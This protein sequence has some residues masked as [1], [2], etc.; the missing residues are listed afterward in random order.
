MRTGIH[1]PAKPGAPMAIPLFWHTKPTPP[2]PVGRALPRR[3]GWAL[4]AAALLA[5]PAPLLAANPEEPAAI[6]DGK[7]LTYQELNTAEIFK[8]R[9]E[10]Y[11]TEQMTLIDMALE[12]LRER[13]PTEFPIPS[14]GISQKE[15]QQ[16]YKASGLEKRGSLDK[17]EKGIR[18]YLTQMKVFKANQELF[19][20]AVKKGYVQN[21][22]R[23]PA[24]FVSSLKYLNSPASLG[25]QNA[26]VHIV[27][28]SDFQCPYCNSARQTLEQLV[29][30]RGKQLR[31]T[32]RHFPLESIH[33]MA[34]PAAL[35]SMCAADQGRF[36][37]YHDLLF[38]NAHD[39]TPPMLLSL[40]D[41]AGIKDPKEFAACLKSGK[42]ENQVQQD[43]TAGGRL[44]VE[45]T[46]TFLIGKLVNGEI[47]GTLLVGALPLEAFEQAVDGVLK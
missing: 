19:Q 32:Y 30:K 38:E 28:F 15:I 45:S 10:L 22:L 29:A 7:P 25:N 39:L 6:I 1:T 44:G 16:F 46:P 9:Q 42:Y 5:G 40:A 26:P 14:V 8:L 37:P 18:G 17:M 36:W 41:K 31:V 3:L 35:A 21:N 11:Q 43:M 20:K 27:E 24:Q 13:H 47:R 34:R 2:A 23:P 4:L 12:R 33:P